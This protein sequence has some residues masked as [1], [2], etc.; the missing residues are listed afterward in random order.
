MC[1]YVYASMCAGASG[2]RRGLRWPEPGVMGYYELL[3]WVPSAK[4][5]LSAR[6]ASAFNC[7]AIFQVLIQIFNPVI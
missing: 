4:V 2:I 3:M 1:V 5:G 7:R 6:A